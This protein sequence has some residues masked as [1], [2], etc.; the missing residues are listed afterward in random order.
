MVML[1]GYFDANAT[2]PLHPAAREAWLAASDKWWHN[3]ASLYHEAAAAKACLEDCRERA[4]A[5]LGCAPADIIFT[6]GATESNN[7]VFH[8]AALHGWSVAHSSLEHP[9]VREAA[10][11]SGVP[12][13]FEV[14]VQENGTISLNELSKV[15]H[16]NKPG[17][18]SLM[19]AN[20]ETGVIQPWGEALS[21]CRQHGAYF[22]TDAVQWAGRLPSSGLGACDFVSMSAHKFGGPKGTGLLKCPA[23][24]V[25]FKSLRGGPQEMRRRAGT[26]NLPSIHAMLAAWEAADEMARN[27]AASGHALQ[28]RQAFESA[29]QEAVPGVEIIAP[30]ASRL[31]NTVMLIMPSQRNVKWLT[32]LSRAGFAV[33]TGSACSSGSGASEVLAAMGVPADA[34]SRVLR[35]SSLWLTAAEDWKA[36]G[37]AFRSVAAGINDK[38]D[39]LRS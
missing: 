38:P 21:L 17:L 5:L 14:P 34:L 27:E 15:L 33:S 2:S 36:L 18:V 23:T 19:A 7:A 31:W 3:P 9:S 25:P 28:M 13:F 26:E 16:D 1:S 30:H 10:A 24:G 12:A 35:V 11:A 32:R 37:R 6:S 39:A 8:H 22:H 29:V 4:G 20:N